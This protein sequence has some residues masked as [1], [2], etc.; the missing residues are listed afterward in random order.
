[1]KHAVIIAHPNAD[2]LTCSIGRAYAKHVKLLGQEAVVRDLY[3]M[4]FDPCLKACEIPTPTGFEF[5][6][7]VVAERKLLADVDVFALVYPF[8]F[9]APPAILKGYIDRVFSMGFGYEPGLGGAQPLLDGK[10]LISFS[11]SGAPE[12]W[13]RETGAFRA[14][15]ALFDQHVS[16]MCGLQMVDHVHTGGIVSDMRDDAV[17]DVFLGVRRAI[18]AH[19]GALAR[20]DQAHLRNGT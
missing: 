11:T 13:V 17:E 9:N 2:S 12:H 16:A 8:W 5:G 15:V 3:R 7:D 19:F 1:M 4:G 20:R 10:R 18:D 6:A 14:L